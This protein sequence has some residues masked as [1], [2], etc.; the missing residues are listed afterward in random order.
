[1]ANYVTEEVKNPKKTMPAA[2]LGSLLLV[3]CL[4]LLV[5]TAYYVVLTKQEVNTAYYSVLTTQYLLLSIYYSVLTTQYLLLSAYYS[6]LT[7]QY[8]LLSAYYSV[9]TTQYLLLSACVEGAG[10]KCGGSGLGAEACG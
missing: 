1:M 2:I 3:T 8:L 5:N 9:L 6:V 4:Y 7:T 10:V